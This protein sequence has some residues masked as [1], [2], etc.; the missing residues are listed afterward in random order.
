[1]SMNN[2]LGNDEVTGSHPL[3]LKMAKYTQVTWT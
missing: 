3:E 2:G 1:M